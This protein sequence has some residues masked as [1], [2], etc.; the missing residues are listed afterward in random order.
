MAALTQTLNNTEE[1]LVLVDQQDSAVKTKVDFMTA[2]AQ[3]L[4]RTVL[5]LLDQVEF[6]KNSDIRGKMSKIKFSFSF[7]KPQ[8]QDLISDTS[9]LQHFIFQLS[10][11]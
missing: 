7:M 1:T 10:H 3:K 6:I 4:E 5:E 8:G 2:D 11:M 9:P